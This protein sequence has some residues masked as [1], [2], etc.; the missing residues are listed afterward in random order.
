[1][2]S[3]LD[4]NFVDEFDKELYEEFL[5]LKSDFNEYAPINNDINILHLI[6]KSVFQFFDKFLKTNSEKV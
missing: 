2:E 3:D 6:E 5:N 4:F 1:M